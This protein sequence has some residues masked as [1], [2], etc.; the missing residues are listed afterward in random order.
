MALEFYKKKVADLETELQNT[1]TFL[2]MV[3]HDLRNPINNINY[4]LDSGL[5]AIK[6][7]EKLLDSYE[8]DLLNDLFVWKMPMINEINDF[9]DEMIDEFR[10]D[11]QEEAKVSAE[12]QS[13]VKNVPIYDPKS[14]NFGNSGEKNNESNP[15]SNL[16]NARE[17]AN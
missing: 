2:N 8:Q 14:A 13:N 11:N 10:L 16:R 15:S 12:P 6:L 1:K 3:I 5:D 9:E 4:G 17:K 7:A